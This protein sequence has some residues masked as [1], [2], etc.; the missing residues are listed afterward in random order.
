MEI[1]KTIHQIWFQGK[2]EI[3]PHL[4]EYHDTWVTLN[5][6]YEILIWDKT[7]I[8]NLIKE[9]EGWIK[10]TYFSYKKMIQKIDFAKYV[11]LYTYG[12]I[13]IDMDI[14]CLQSIDNTPSIAESDI[15]LSLMPTNLPQKIV[16]AVVGSMSISN[17]PI[18]NNGTIMCIPKNKLIL[19]TMKEA[20]N[21]K[22]F[23]NINNSIHIFATTGPLCLSKA[24]K[25]YMEKTNNKDNYKIHILDKSYFENCDIFEV[26]NNSC[27]IPKHAIGLHYYENSWTS[28][29]EKNMIS[30]MNVFV[31]YW[32]VVLIC[33]L[34]TAYILFKNFKSTPSIKDIRL[35]RRRLRPRK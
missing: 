2:A 9:Q 34:I 31:K 5:P 7:K 17:D 14:K 4:L 21:R 25:L 20:Y 30:L 24:Y 32:Y 12:G 23:P 6:K 22:D 18:I 28:K 27:S 13:Y 29:S 26:N 19:L 16:L 15:I 35:K 8:E 1:P 33:F 11:I 10:D 3:P